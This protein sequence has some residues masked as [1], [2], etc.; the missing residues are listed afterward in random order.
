M[1]KTHLRVSG[2]DKRNQGQTEF[3]FTHQSACGYVRDKITVNHWE[4]DCFYCKRTKEFDE[5]ENY[6]GEGL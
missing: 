5:L 1:S 3:E 6:D 2:V 4:V